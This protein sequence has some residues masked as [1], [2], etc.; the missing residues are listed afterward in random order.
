MHLD[1]VE[2]RVRHSGQTQLVDRNC[3]EH[4][5]KGDLTNWKKNSMYNN[6]TL[7]A[8]MKTDITLLCKKINIYIIWCLVSGNFLV[9]IC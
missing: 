2:G 7:L 6:I 9:D 4:C 5:E 3:E 1:V 8:K